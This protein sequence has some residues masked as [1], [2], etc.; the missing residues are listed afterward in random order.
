MCQW[1]VNSKACPSIEEI[2]A[3]IMCVAS[4]LCQ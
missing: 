3:T 1:K 4:D 2:D